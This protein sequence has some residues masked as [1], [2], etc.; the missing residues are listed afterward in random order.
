MEASSSPDRR[1]LLVLLAA[2]AISLTGNRLSMLAVPWFVLQTTGS[3][4]L[5]GVTGFFTLLPIVLS[6]L[7][8]GV[9]VDRLGYRPASIVSD[10]ASGLTIALIPALHAAG[11]LEFWVLLTLTFLGAL[12]DTPGATARAAL[13]P[14]L[15]E[16]GGA[17]I[18]WATSATQIVDRGARLL[19]APLAGAL[20]ALVGPTTVLW[21]DA[22]TFAVS[23]LMFAVAIP[24]GFAA[25]R[26]EPSAGYLADFKAGLAFIRGDRLIFAILLFLVVPNFLDTAWA[27]VAAPVLARD[28]YGSAVALGLFFGASGGG[29]VAGAL[30]CGAVGYRFPRRTVFIT[31]FVIAGTA[32]L[33]LATFPPLPVAVAIQV[34]AGVAAGPLNPILG[35][36]EYER[37]PAGMRGRVFGAM[38]AAAW[39][40]MPLGALLAGPLVVGLGL[41]GTLLAVGGCYL[42]ATVSM[43]FSPTLREMDARR[44]S[45]AAASEGLG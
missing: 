11:R 5:T 24:G 1:P 30:L 44:P 37:I 6:A 39:G 29:A 4:T 45:P 43:L 42:A 38:T 8:G 21:I 17:P 31:G 20:I 14:E 15:A 25:S 27:T 28:V 19:G 7:F 36:V 16:R 23:A 32:P 10:L 40:A 18:E 13:L 41:R 26:E 33:F 2:N 12:L 22:G 9:V 3:A 34:I 35:A